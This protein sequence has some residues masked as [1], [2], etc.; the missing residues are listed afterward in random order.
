MADPAATSPP[1][2]PP[3]DLLA[4]IQGGPPTTPGND[5]AA[6]PSSSSLTSPSS[7]ASPDPKQ[8]LAE[9]SAVLER[10]SQAMAEA[11]R[12]LRLVASAEIAPRHRL[13]AAGEG[14][15]APTHA[16]QR[17]Q[18]RLERQG[19]RRRPPL[20]SGAQARAAA[21]SADREAHGKR[22]ASRVDQLAMEQGRM[23]VAR[24]QEAA[25]NSRARAE[26]A[27]A[28]VPPLAER[29]P[30]GEARRCLCSEG[31]APPPAVGGMAPHGTAGPAR[32]I[33]R[34]GVA[35][36]ASSFP[37]VSAQDS[38]LCADCE[39]CTSHPCV[40][41]AL[42]LPTIIRRGKNV[43][44][45]H[46]HSQWAVQCSEAALHLMPAAACVARLRAARHTPVL[47]GSGQLPPFSVRPS[48][49]VLPPVADADADI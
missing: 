48:C 21:E 27:R 22:E 43:G 16:A 4:F 17:W 23:E 28:A 37:S 12:Q 18:P 10:A 13:A 7:L 15:L 46:T 31:A 41:L 47:R 29:W 19:L 6:A 25:E 5:D 32:S 39:S 26:T 9:A 42:S 8:R 44:T 35:P 2:E 1:N 34:Q 14:S 3:P 38:A 24:C 49:E 20:L 33:A 11:G 45:R 30:R 40:H 36:A